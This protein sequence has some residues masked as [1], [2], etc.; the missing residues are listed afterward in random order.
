VLATE[1]LA[2]NCNLDSKNPTGKEG[3]TH[4]PPEQL[5]ESILHKEHRIAEI[6][7]NIKALLAES[8]A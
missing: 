6:M 1:L 4:L 5:V 3:I 2:N 8:A 7:G